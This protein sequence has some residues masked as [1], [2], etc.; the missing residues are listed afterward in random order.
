MRTVDLWQRI[1]L[2]ILQAVHCES[3]AF[4]LPFIAPFWGVVSLNS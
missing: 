4:V 1:P 2:N 3:A